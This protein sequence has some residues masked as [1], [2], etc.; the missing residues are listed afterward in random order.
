ML[1]LT[2]ENDEQ[3]RKVNVGMT[4]KPFEMDVDAEKD[5]TRREILKMLEAVLGPHR[6]AAA[7]AA[8]MQKARWKLRLVRAKHALAQFLVLK[9]VALPLSHSHKRHRPSDLLP[10][11]TCAHVVT[12][13]CDCS[14]SIRQVPK[15]QLRLC[16]QQRKWLYRIEKGK[17]SLGRRRSALSP[18]L[19]STL[20][21]LANHH[22]YLS[23]AYRTLTIT[24]SRRHV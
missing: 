1:S 17:E 3:L 18:S 6:P 9:S 20:L 15:Q 14:T 13:L 16:Q 22:L 19:P 5:P 11:V 4:P 2:T 12:L 21:H 23:F 7:A 10:T 8:L 24:S